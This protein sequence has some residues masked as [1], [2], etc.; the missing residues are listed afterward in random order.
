M[1]SLARQRKQRA[2]ATVLEDIQTATTLEGGIPAQQRA[3]D[4]ARRLALKAARLALKA[5][6]KS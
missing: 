6:L 1:V 4:R 5:W 2:V 3:Y